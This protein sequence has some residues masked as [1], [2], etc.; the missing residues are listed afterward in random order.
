MVSKLPNKTP[1]KIISFLQFHS[2]QQNANPKSHV[3][4]VLSLILQRESK[5]QKRL[6]KVPEKAAL[7]ISSQSQNL[8]HQRV[9]TRQET[10]KCSVSTKI[11]LIYKFTFVGILLSNNVQPKIKTLLGILVFH[12]PVKLCKRL[13]SKLGPF[14]IPS[15]TML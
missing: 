8:I 2:P 5:R 10:N 4:K 12:I 11:F 15:N 7:S 3:E 9:V 14:K 13:S 1:L 6:S